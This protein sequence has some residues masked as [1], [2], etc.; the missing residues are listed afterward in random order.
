MINALEV[1]LGIISILAIL[2]LVAFLRCIRP[3]VRS[4]A[5][6]QSN[7][8]GRTASD[9]NASRGHVGV[10][11]RAS[12]YAVEEGVTGG[13]SQ[14]TLQ[15]CPKVIYSEKIVDIRSQPVSERHDARQIMNSCAICLQDYQELEDYQDS[16]DV[17]RLL[18]ECGHMFHVACIDQ[19]LAFHATCPIC[20]YS[21]EPSHCT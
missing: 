15:A 21:L 14:A 10:L 2:F 8:A 13:I 3:F 9:R 18:P 4:L 16:V 6:N 20:R 5:M 19:W 7:A 11:Q 17:L 12:T 1:T